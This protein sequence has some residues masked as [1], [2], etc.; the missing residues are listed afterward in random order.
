MWFDQKI[1]FQFIDDASL[2]VLY[3]CEFVEADSAEFPAS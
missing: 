1:G 3:A 2:V